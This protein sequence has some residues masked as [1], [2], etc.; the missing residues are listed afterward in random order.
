[1]GSISAVKLRNSTFKDNAI[2]AVTIKI[3][4][5]MIYSK[6]LSLN[7]ST[8]FNLITEIDPDHYLAIYISCN[9]ENS[10]DASTVFLQPASSLL[11]IGS[12]SAMLQSNSLQL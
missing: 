5:A 11:H 10:Y 12:L 8:V 6:S 4:V 9:I 1:M 3:Y 7:A 2:L